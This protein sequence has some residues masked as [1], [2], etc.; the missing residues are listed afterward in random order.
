MVDTVHFEHVQGVLHVR[1]ERS[2]RGGMDVPG[3][4][5]A[6]QNGDSIPFDFGDSD[7]TW[8]DDVHAALDES[9]GGTSAFLD[10]DDFAWLDALVPPVG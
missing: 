9:E 7:V 1:A 4:Q 10:E 5:G 3:G 8:L 6:Q 2:T